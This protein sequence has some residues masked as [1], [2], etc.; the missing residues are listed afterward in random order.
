M[1]SYHEVLPNE[2]NKQHEEGVRRIQDLFRKTELVSK[3]QELNLNR[4]Q[5]QQQEKA[6]GTKKKHK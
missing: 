4:E 6:E 5:E 1:C 2:M 3:I